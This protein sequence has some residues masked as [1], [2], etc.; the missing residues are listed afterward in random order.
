[1]EKETVETVL[2]LH[3]STI[4][5]T[6]EQINELCNN[7]EYGVF[8]FDKHIINVSVE[9][10]FERRPE[11]IHCVMKDKLHSY[12]GEFRA[13]DWAFTDWE[14]ADLAELQGQRSEVCVKCKQQRNK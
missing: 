6:K 7:L 8:E 14:H 9:E 10:S 12:C 11:W 5:M 3:V 4:D 13:Y 2:V 1:M